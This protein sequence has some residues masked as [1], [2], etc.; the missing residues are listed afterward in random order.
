MTNVNPPPEF[1]QPAVSAVAKILDQSPKCTDT[2]GK[3][4]VPRTLLSKNA[5]VQAWQVTKVPPST[6]IKKRIMYNP[7]AV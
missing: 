1:P 4:P 5:V 7:V 2:R 6:P 3:V